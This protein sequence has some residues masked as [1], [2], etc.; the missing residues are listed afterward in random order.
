LLLILATALALF[1][2]YKHRRN[3]TLR[4]LIPIIL[5]AT[6]NGAFMSQQLWGSTYA[7]WPLLILLAAEMLAFLASSPTESSPAK[8]RPALVIAAVFSA[9]LLIC[10]A[11]YTASEERLSYAQFPDEPAQHSAFPQLAGM[12][13]PGPYLSNFDEL[14]RYAAAN[15]PASDGVIL[16]PGEDPFYFVTGRKPQF[17]VLLFDPATDPYSPAQVAGQAR[18]HNIRWLIIKRN[19]QI[20]EDPTPQ[21][22]ATLNA[23]LKDFTLSAYL[24]GYDVY[25][26]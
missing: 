5:L 22:E 26:R 17:P 7:F 21:R 1:N 4:S 12:A 6:I 19:L 14:L 13:T 11:F 24:H 8:Q 23:L 3:L 9:T 16:I 10:G 25:R 15:I 18:L 2:I 20:K